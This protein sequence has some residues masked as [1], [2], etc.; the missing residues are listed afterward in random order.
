M[1]GRP[2][3]TAAEI[4]A[5][6][7]R[8]MASGISVHELMDRAGQAA[9]DA[10]WHFAGGVP[11]LVACGP[12]NNGGDGY[13]IAR[14][15]KARGA[16]VRVAASADPQTPAAIAARDAWDGPVGRLEDAVPG[17]LLIDA[18]FGT[19]LSRGLDDAVAGQLARLANGARRRI[20]IDL[21]SGVA[22]DSGALLSVVPDY[23]LTVALGTL[24]PAHLL[25][26]AARHMGRLVT[27]DIGLGTIE[28]QL[29]V[30][31]RPILR[32]PDPDAHKYSRG[33]VA[34]IG[35][36]MAG[37]AIL[38]ASAAQRAGAGMV[39]LSGMARGGPAAL[40]H[41]S[42]DAILDDERVGALVIGPGLVPGD[43]ATASLDRA[44]ESGFPLVMDAGALR[45][46]GNDAT[47]RLKQLG[48]W[49]ILTPHEGEFKEMFGDLAGSKI[50]RTREA[51]RVSGAV[52]ILKGPDTVIATPSGDAA[53]SA[54]AP[55]WL[56]SAGT[57][58][59]LAGIVAAC[60][61]SGLPTFKAAKAGVWLHGE[62][63]RLAGPALIADD[64]VD[65]LPVAFAACL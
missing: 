60:L 15:L 38:A 49:P 39:V 37:A 19:G 34:V 27:A 32:A 48:S 3:L 7:E 10:A 51:A 53:I 42:E 54:N 33:L 47:D 52:I 45:L 28:S 8:V 11:T 20:A 36:T 35:G 9:A 2:I 50:E 46:L 62:T 30:V 43:S 4:R 5:A 64:L 44:L 6:E 56:A 31:E 23:D 61:A 17:N 18:L 14:C 41:R 58:D 59:V 55:P 1:N 13:V 21:P 16:D 26:P 65:H 25:Q 57:G 29:H 40:V 24:K 22:T 12:G 63:A